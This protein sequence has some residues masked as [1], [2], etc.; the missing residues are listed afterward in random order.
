MDVALTNGQG[1]MVEDKH[2]M[3]Y[4]SVVKEPHLVWT[5]FGLVSKLNYLTRGHHV[6]T[7][8]ES[9]QPTPTIDA[10]TG[11]VACCCARHGCFIPTSVCDLQKG[12]W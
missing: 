9:T 1:F 7:I 8:E 6:R 2:Y 12:E 5:Y 4:L 11:V 3:D 10:T